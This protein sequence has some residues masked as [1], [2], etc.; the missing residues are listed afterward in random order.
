[1]K[2]QKQVS[3]KVKNK[4]YMKHVIVVPSDEV[5]KLGWKEDQELEYEVSQDT[6]VVKPIAKKR[7]AET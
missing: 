5:E 7:K 6:L 3:R 2:L 4:E 1:M